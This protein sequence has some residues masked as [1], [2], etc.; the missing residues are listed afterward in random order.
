[1][2][3]NNLANLN[4]SRV[5][6]QL[7]GNITQIAV[8]CWRHCL[9]IQKFDSSLKVYCE[10]IYIAMSKLGRNLHEN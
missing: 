1:M 2:F 10:V 5:D 8:M 9:E 6:L 3:Y 7:Q 4:Q